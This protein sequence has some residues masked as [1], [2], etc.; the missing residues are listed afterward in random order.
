M[1]RKLLPICLFA[2]LCLLVT[3][4]SSRMPGSM[5][6]RGV[7]S[8][9]EYAEEDGLAKDVSDSK[10]AKQLSENTNKDLKT[11]KLIKDV[12][13][14]IE[15]REFDKFMQ[16]LDIEISKCGGF[17]QKSDIN[18]NSYKVDSDRR[19]SIVIRIPADKLDSFTGNISSLGNVTSRTEGTQDVTMDYVD[20]QSHIKALRT[21]H[22]SL[23]ALLKKADNL[24]DILTIQNHLT[25]VRYELES[26]ESKLRTYDDLIDYSTV[27]MNVYEVERVTP[28]E[29]L[30][31]WQEIGNNISK[32][33]SSIGKGA[34]RLFIWIISASPYLLIL[35]AIALIV[36]F[37][38]RKSIKK[39]RHIRQEIDAQNITN[40]PEHK[41]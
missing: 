7:N 25:D 4:C 13:L 38:T 17:I 34:R 11:R 23:L 36:A 5:D 28:T 1:K 31:M 21:E 29:K 6:N 15:T 14:T 27:T 8:E 30:S 24:N 35:A 22:E 10:G 3:A 9:Y 32:N 40:G 18:G 16:N 33:L 26:Y 19:A 2:A 41:D 12:T 37:A 20:I 39:S